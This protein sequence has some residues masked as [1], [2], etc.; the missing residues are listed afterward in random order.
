MFYRVIVL[1]FFLWSVT[2]KVEAISKIA[3]AFYNVENLFDTIDNPR[4]NDNDFTPK[5]KNGWNT[6]RYS[7]KISR[8]ATVVKD[9]EQSLRIP[10]AVIGLC[11]VENFEVLQDLVNGKELQH[12]DYGIIIHPSSDQRG[13]AVGFIYRKDLFFP[14]YD[15]IYKVNFL[16]DPNTTTR[17]QL[18]VSGTVDRDTLHF[19]T[20]HYPSRFGGQLRSEHKR[21][22]AAS[23]TRKIVEK[24][25]NQYSNPKIIIFGDL[26]DTPFDKSVTRV[27]RAKEHTTSSSDLFNTTYVLAQQGYGTIAYRK[28]WYMFDQILISTPL[29]RA[30]YGYG[31]DTTAIFTSP[32]LIL[33]SSKNEGLPFRTFEAGEHIGGYSDHFPVYMILR[34]LDITP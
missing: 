34:K 23:V 1:F 5:G 25:Q 2:F 6:K 3:V 17:D 22:S 20:L 14:F 8:I 28:R 27:L 12:N 30:T 15:T 32:K 29:H 31:Y 9:L 19:V 26:N 13:L 24:L 10:L 33:S 16:D 4:K 11:E 18:L 21:L 7:N